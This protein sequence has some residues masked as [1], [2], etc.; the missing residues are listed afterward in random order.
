MVFKAIPTFLVF[1]TS[2]QNVYNS[3]AK[4]SVQRDDS[5]I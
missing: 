2:L 1:E 5:C 4:F 3:Y